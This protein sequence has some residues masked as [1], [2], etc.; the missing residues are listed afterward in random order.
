MS[1]CCGTKLC[2]C[3]CIYS[4]LFPSFI[5]MQS[6]VDLEMMLFTTHQIALDGLVSAVWEWVFTRLNIS[7][8]PASGFD[9]SL[10]YC[11]CA[12]CGLLLGSLVSSIFQKNMPVYWL[13]T[14]SWLPGWINVCMMDWFIIHCDLLSHPQ[15]SWDR[16]RYILDTP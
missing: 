12:L 2:L 1:V 13:I 6:P 7:P 11:L 16:N 10:G 3:L 5:S 9:L 8:L 4:P 14:L 15:C